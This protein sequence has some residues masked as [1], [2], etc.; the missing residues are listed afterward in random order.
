MRL[1]LAFEKALRDVVEEEYGDALDFYGALNTDQQETELGY[2]QNPDYPLEDPDEAFDNWVID[3]DDQDEFEDWEENGTDSDTYAKYKDSESFKRHLNDVQ[4]DQKCYFHFLLA[5]ESADLAIDILKTGALAELVKKALNKM[6]NPKEFENCEILNEWGSVKPIT[7]SLEKYRK[8][9]PH[10]ILSQ[11]VLQVF[12][13][14]IVLD[15][16][17]P[18]YRSW[19]GVEDLDIARF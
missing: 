7:F 14:V 6:G 2:G 10:K 9:D 12:P 13:N 17:K 3:L 15:G 19:G 16:V 18:V 4:S 5:P 11:M 8:N 1:D